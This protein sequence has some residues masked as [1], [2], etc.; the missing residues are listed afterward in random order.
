MNRV[1]FQSERYRPGSRYNLEG[2]GLWSDTGTE[3]EREEHL[4]M[5]KD[6]K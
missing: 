1:R 4:E 2:Q 5:A 3:S 6:R